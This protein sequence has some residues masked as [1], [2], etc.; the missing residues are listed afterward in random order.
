MAENIKVKDLPDTSSV[1]MTEELMVLVD[2]TNN[3]V[4]NISISDFNT[5]IISNT[6][7]N[8]IVKDGNNNKLYAFD[9]TTITGQL[10]DLTTTDK[11]S[12]VNAINE[13]NSPLNSDF[14]NNSK[15]LTTGAISNDTT[16][17]D[18]ICGY[19]YSNFDLA[20]YTK[21]GSPAISSDGVMSNISNLNF[22]TID[23]SNITYS[24]S[25]EIILPI[26]RD[27][28]GTAQWFLS[29]TT[30]SAANGG[31]WLGFSAINELRFFA[32][33]GT[34]S[35]WDIASDKKSN[36][37]FTDTISKYYIKL[38]FTGSQ[39]L[40]YYSQNKKTW[41]SL[42][43]MTV[44]SSTIAPITNGIRLGFGSSS[45]YL[46][47]NYYLS[48]VSIKADGFPVFNGVKTGV[49]TIKPVNYTKVSGV[50]VSDD[51]IA[52]NFS[53]SNYITFP[54]I[55]VTGKTF[56]IDFGK[57][58]PT[59]LTTTQY[60]LSGQSANTF[61]VFIA[62]SSSKLGITATTDSIYSAE[63]AANTS[64]F[65]KAGF[66]GINI[67]IK[68]STD[69][70]NYTTYENAT[71]VTFTTLA[72]RLG[73]SYINAAQ[74]LS[75]M[76]LNTI[77]V[78]ADGELVYQP[79]LNV[80]YLLSKTGAKIADVSFRNIA[81]DMFLQKGYAPYYTIDENNLTFTLP[82]GELYGL[83]AQS[84]PLTSYKNGINFWELYQ[85]GK[86]VQG[87]SCTSGTAVT[88]QKDFA[89]TNYILTV[90]YSAKSATGFTPSQTGDWL[91][92][93]YV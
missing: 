69:G 61:S 21:T 91:A 76:N 11:T 41:T 80:A 73:N 81:K 39:Y 35:S 68:I 72:L 31:F 62:G 4:N 45:A 36:Y 93:G 56:E 63:L 51:G 17:Y 10:S 86:L 23:T 44:T 8:A 46:H 82:M 52:S 74:W 47:G 70:E 42:P 7:N 58:T 84:V 88:F 3:I 38:V 43:E 85:T 13:I 29:N 30:N 22:V 37:K 20:K 5:N 14:I 87:G 6:A 60:F 65:V 64:Y 77:K 28:V 25:L 90:P 32:S 79:C 50:V 9:A 27:S 59:A 67:Y 19:A 24:N 33:S 40:S 57:I 12:L 2:S 1:Q 75:N 16:L 48:E 53:T 34:G 89:D 26:K 18:E 92:I 78:Y 71:S 54:S 55:D 49:D 15:A 66:D 83:I